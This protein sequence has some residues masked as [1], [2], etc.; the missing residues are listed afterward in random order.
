MTY[1]AAQLRESIVGLFDEAAQRSRYAFAFEERERFQI[2][3]RA[4]KPLPENHFIC[5]LCRARAPDHR[6]PGY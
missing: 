6:C 3:R 1:A 4:M 2:I 5:D